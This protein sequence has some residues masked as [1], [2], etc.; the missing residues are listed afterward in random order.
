MYI[1]QTRPNPSCCPSLS[2]KTC[3]ALAAHSLVMAVGHKLHYII[4]PCAKAD[5]EIDFEHANPEY[6]SNVRK[7]VRASAL[8]IVS[9]NHNVD[10]LNKTATT[11]SASQIVF[12]SIVSTIKQVVITLLIRTKRRWRKEKEMSSLPLLLVVQQLLMQYR[13][14]KLKMGRPVT[15]N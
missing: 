9:K 14:L 7:N 15:N 10:T 5:Y 12:G 3:H 6:A 1:T 4:C 11:S 2:Q 13:L 8:A